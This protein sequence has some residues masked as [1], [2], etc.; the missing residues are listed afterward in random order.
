MDAIHHLEAFKHLIV[1]LHSTTGGQVVEERAR[2][3]K[4]FYAKLCIKSVT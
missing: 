4:E 2:I 3:Q 1:K